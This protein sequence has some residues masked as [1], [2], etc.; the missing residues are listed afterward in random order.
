MLTFAERRLDER[1]RTNDELRVFHE[2]HPRPRTCLGRIIHLAAFMKIVDGQL[3]CKVRLLQ[4]RTDPPKEW[5]T[6]LRAEILR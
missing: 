1:V 3:A 4:V 6:V 5:N 2:E